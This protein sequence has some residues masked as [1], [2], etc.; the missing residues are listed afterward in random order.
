MRFF[1]LVHDLAGPGLDVD[2]TVVIGTSLKGR[3][4]IAQH[5]FVTN[6][7][8]QLRT[9]LTVLNV[10][11]TFALRRI[12][13]DDQ[14]SALI[15]IQVGVAQM[16]RLAEQL[17]T[18]SRAEPG[19]CRLR[20]DRVALGRFASRVLKDTAARA[21]AKSLDL[22]LDERA[23]VVVIGDETMFV[24]MLANL[25]D[26][27]M[28]YCRSESSVTLAVDREGG[29]AIQRVEDDGPRLRQLRAAETA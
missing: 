2:V 4:S 29:T 28:R 14:A 22:G 8:H 13:T 24:E 3:D 5:R 7:A 11:A 16:S 10:Q 21:M 26:N 27:A 20:N 23:R 18:L 15:A 1:S 19:S 17:L 9:P 12:G 25:V 6:A